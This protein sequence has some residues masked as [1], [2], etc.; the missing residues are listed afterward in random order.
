MAL[1]DHRLE[2]R[3]IARALRDRAIA[4][5][6]APERLIEPRRD[7]HAIGR[8]RPKPTDQPQRRTTLSRGLAD[9]AEHE[10]V[11]RHDAATEQRAGEPQR[12]VG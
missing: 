10:V 12:I 7:Q 11:H 6:R 4:H 3:R 5:R 9:E 1:C 8:E 2:R